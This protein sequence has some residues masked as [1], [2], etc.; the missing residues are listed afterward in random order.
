[1][2]MIINLMEMRNYNKIQI[3]KVMIKMRIKTEA[4]KILKKKNPRVRNA[5]INFVITK[6]FI[7]NSDPKFNMQ[8]TG[9]Y[10]DNVM[11]TTAIMIF[12]NSANKYIPIL[13]TPKMTTSGSDVM[14]VADGYF[15][16][17]FRIIFNVRKN[18]GIKIYIK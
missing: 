11:R 6:R 18:T 1:M 3:S 15:K 14:N 9:S 13:G 8:N 17:I 12:V 4:D 5:S 7:K 2:S 10:A 16:F